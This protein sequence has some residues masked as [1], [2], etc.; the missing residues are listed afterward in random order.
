M[1]YAAITHFKDKFHLS[2]KQLRTASTA[3]R[4][5]ELWCTSGVWFWGAGVALG[6]GAIGLQCV[7]VPIPASVGV[8]SI[9]FGVVM[10]GK[11]VVLQQGF[12]ALHKKCQAEMEKR[13]LVPT[14]T[15]ADGSGPKTFCGIS[16]PRRPFNVRGRAKAILG[17]TQPAPKPNS[18]GVNFRLRL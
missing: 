2:D 13:H 9:V 8:S 5:A 4:A 17:P 18:T 12:R 10:A 11:S 14:I 6:V 7:G 16:F 1:P 15:V 3:A